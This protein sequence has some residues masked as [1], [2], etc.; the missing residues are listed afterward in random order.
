[1]CFEI[2]FD[3][4]SKVVAFST[5]VFGLFR[6]FA[7]YRNT[8]RWKKAEFLAKEAKEFFADPNVKRAL[9]ILDYRENDI[10][11]YNGELAGQVTSIH[12]DQGILLKALT[13]KDVVETMSP[14]DRLIRQIFDEFLTKLSYFNRYID[15]KLITLDDLMPYM[16]YWMN[17]LGNPDSGK[18]SRTVMK[19]I[20]EFIDFYEYDDV[21]SLTRKFGFEPVFIPGST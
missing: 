1:M 21:R 12:F 20:W 14:E 8:Q 17:I 16:R 15:T 18:R 3:T 10:P 6:A 7:E 2:N 11:V 5:A 4:L 9:I 19:Q 13:V